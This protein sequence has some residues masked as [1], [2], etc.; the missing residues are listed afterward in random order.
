MFERFNDDARRAV[1]A[2]QEEARAL[3]A[4]SI[5][6]AHLLIALSRTDGIA[7]TVLAA[8]GD[9][10]T[11]RD[12]YAARRENDAPQ[13]GGHL[14][15]DAAAKRTLE[16]AL[17]EALSLGHAHI[18]TEHILL[19]LL[20]EADPLV[21]GML[22]ATGAD[23]QHLRTDVLRELASRSGI[24]TEAT[25]EREPVQ[26]E[27]QTNVLEAF[28]RDL[29][30]MAEAGTLDRVVGRDAEIE[31]VVQTLCRRTKNNPCLVGDPGV[32]KTA[33][34]EGLA[35]RIVAGDV[36]DVIKGFRIH[37]LDLGGMVAGSRY[38]GDF[39][40]RV[41]K[42]LREL[43]SRRDV[44]V[45][46]DEIHTLV[47]AGAGE[48]ALDAANLLKPALARGELRV[49][50]ATTTDEFRKHIEKDPALERRFQKVNVA[51][52]SRDDTVE[53]LRGL[54]PAYAEHHGVEIDDAALV[55][56]VDLS[57]RYVTDRQFPDKAIDL[58]DESGSYL[59]IH[60]ELPRTLTADVVADVCSRA[61]GIP[62]RRDAAETARLVGMEAVLHERVIGQ[63]QAVSVVSRAVRRSRA[64]LRDNRRPVGSFLFLGPTG[65][66]KT[67]L[68][69]TL[70]EFLFG[71]ADALCTIDM[72]EY[73]E[74]HTVSRLIGAPPGYV[75]FN[76]PGQLTEAV[77]RRPYS[78]VL[79]DEVEKAHPDVFN[80][81]LQV[82][83]EGRLT[84]ATGRNVDFSH[85]VVIA[86][87]NL[88]SAEFHRAA[89]GFSNRNQDTSHDRLRELA[90]AQAK[91]FFRPELLNRIDE[92]V[93]FH[94]LAP[95]EVRRIAEL[96]VAGVRDRLAGHGVTLTLSPAALDHLAAVGFDAELGA[97]PLRR[98]I[99][100][101]LEDELAERLL[102]GEFVAGDQV[103]VDVLDVGSLDA[104]SA[105]R[106]TTSRAELVFVVVKPDPT[107]TQPV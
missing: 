100:T 28:G 101:K 48:G 76:E 64:A 4:S 25:R 92:L 74:K 45:F 29:T 23:P 21:L 88:G 99:Q 104:A 83:E 91:K 18:G 52:P 47:G 84:D 41:K 5:E 13:P 46:L 43:E 96:M 82:L 62:I 33:I 31:R 90:E 34:V 78:V 12:E 19:G 9:T 61:T 71:T 10:A 50:G 2:A 40:E 35:Q 32:G 68:A 106:D 16:S 30:A 69:K 98:C 3:G 22:R 59:R 80:L 20:R 63:D 51:E 1:V 42:V 72:S 38:R 81:L 37:T 8:H 27:K 36:P 58:L 56:A 77:R 97:R 105:G 17:R 85:C 94:R 103:V 73:Q 53:I 15:F 49:V 55:A 89:V 14:P 87:S 95:A 7:A 39:E 86:T 44:I 79:L 107:E 66:G 60:P 24:P 70:A 57:A 102:L 93:V 6:A 67:E 54:A 26:R 65:V 75:G 11:L